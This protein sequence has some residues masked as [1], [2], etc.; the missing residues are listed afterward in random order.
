MNTAGADLDLDLIARLRVPPDLHPPRLTCPR[1]QSTRPGQDVDSCR[2]A[3]AELAEDFIFPQ[4]GRPEP[5]K[6]LVV[7]GEGGVRAGS[8]RAYSGGSWVAHKV[9]EQ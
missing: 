8:A 4:R 2:D 5:G 6:Q 7:G 3:R 1:D 9:R